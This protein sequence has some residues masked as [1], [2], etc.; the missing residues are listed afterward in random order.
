LEKLLALYNIR[1]VTFLDSRQTERKYAFTSK[2]LANNI[3]I[4]Y[5]TINDLAVAADEEEIEDDDIDD[6]DIHYEDMEDD[7]VED[8]Y[9]SQLSVVMKH[10]NKYYQFVMF[11]NTVEIGFPI[12]L[13]QTIIFIVKLIEETEPGK[14]VEYLMSIS[15]APLVPHEISDKE[16]R[17]IANDLLKLKIQTVHELIKDNNARHN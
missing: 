6:V 10:K 5:Y 8:E 3:F 17:D 9:G 2:M 15:P 11:Y 14:L 7:E 4:E 1:S 16:H 12:L 13:L